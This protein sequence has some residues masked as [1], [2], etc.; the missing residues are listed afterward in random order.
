MNKTMPHLSRDHA[1]IQP[2]AGSILAVTMPQMNRDHTASQPW[3]LA[4]SQPWLTVELRSYAVPQCVVSLPESFCSGLRRL[5]Y[6]PTASSGAAIAAQLENKWLSCVT[7]K[8]KNSK[9][10]LA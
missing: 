7:V 8:D 5:L 1:A 6:I 2:L 3:V 10:L 9:G 4:A